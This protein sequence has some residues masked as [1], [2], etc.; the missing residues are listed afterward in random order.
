M[1]PT[2]GDHAPSPQPGVTIEQKVRWGD[3]DAMG[4]VNNTALF[5]YCESARVAYLESLGLDQSEANTAAGLGMVRAALNFRRQVRYPA[6]LTVTANVTATSERSFTLSY[7]IGDAANGQTVADG[8][9]VCVWVD[10][11]QG[12][13]L[14]LPEELVAAI[15][16]VERGGK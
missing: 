6:T 15:A 12:K 9:S 10:Y 1:A 5:Q 16:K 7:I 14:P 13:A 8:E 3:M 4:H 11:R 2:S